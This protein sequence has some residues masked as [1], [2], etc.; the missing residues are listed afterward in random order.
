M[1]LTYLHVVTVE[2][3]TG[4]HFVT[5]YTRNMNEKAGEG[6]T[7]LRGFNMWPVSY[8]EHFKRRSTMSLTYLHVVTVEF[9]TGCHFVTEYTRNMNEKAGEGETNPRD[10]YMRRVDCHLSTT[11]FTG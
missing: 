4:Y 6:A 7:N 9:R 10:S 11:I 2:F 3:R 1:S 8:C 5:E